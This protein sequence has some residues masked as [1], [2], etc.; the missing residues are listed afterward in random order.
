CTDSGYAQE[1]MGSAQVTGNL[2]EAIIA[3]EAEN[4]E[5]MIQLCQI[6]I[7]Q[8][9]HI[10]DGSIA[11]LFPDPPPGWSAGEIESNRMQFGMEDRSFSGIDVKRLYW[12]T[13]GQPAVEE[14][15]E[16]ATPIET[17]LSNIPLVTQLSRSLLEFEGQE[18]MLKMMGLTI[19]AKDNFR[20]ILQVDPEEND[21]AKATITAFG[22]EKILSLTGKKSQVRDLDTLFH[23][24][25]L[26][27]AL[28]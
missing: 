3:A 1:E 26:K 27:G 13:A 23:L 9:R 14:A 7:D 22:K 20:C 19:F 25:D 18:Q 5:K 12:R 8:A 21:Q 6:A 11:D 28:E 24:F 2:K 15:S 10:Q 16:K 4:W 17:H